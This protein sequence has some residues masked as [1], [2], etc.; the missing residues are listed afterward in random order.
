M[1]RLAGANRIVCPVDAGQRVPLP[2]GTPV[3]SMNPSRNRLVLRRAQTVRVASVSQGWIDL[4][5]DC[6]RDGRSGLVILPQIVWAGSGGYWS[7]VKVTPGLCEYWGLPVP[8]LP[9]LD[10]DFDPVD[11]PPQ[12]GAG[13]DDRD[14][15][16]QSPAST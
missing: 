1:P 16:G 12:Y 14:L 5:G 15:F 9:L 3:R 2:A 8:D 13:F 4:W 7:R 6:R 11:L 10:A